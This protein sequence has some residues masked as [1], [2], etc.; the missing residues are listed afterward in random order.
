TKKIYSE[1]GR[2]I[3]PK[4]K[5]VDLIDEL[6]RRRIVPYQVL[7]MM[8]EV[9]KTGNLAV[10]EIHGEKGEA[11]FHLKTVRKIAVWFYKTFCDKHCKVGAFIPPPAPIDASGILKAELE[12]LKA[13]FIA[14]QIRI[15]ELSE[16]AATEA[17]LRALAE[18]QA[19]QAYEE[20]DTAL[21]IGAEDNERLS[22][23]IEKYEALLARQSQENHPTQKELEETVT[24]AV[25]IENE[26]VTEADTREIID[27][28]LRQAGWTVDSKTI[29]HANGARPEKNKCIAISEWPTDSGPADYVLFIG[30]MPVAVVEAKRKNIDVPGKIGQAKRYSKTIRI[31]GDLVAPFDSEPWQNAF[32]IPFMYSANGRPY[33]K[34][35]V[36]KSGIWF[37]DGRRA[38]NISRPLVGWH[39]PEGLKELLKLDVDKTEK[40]L[41][42]SSNDYLPLWP[43][44]REAIESVEKGVIEGRREMLVAMATG[45]GKTR[46]AI[47][48]C[49]R[50]AKAERFRRVLFIVDRTSLGEQAFDSFE[51][52]QLENNQSFT[53]IYDVKEL[54][55]VKP[56]KDTRLQFCTIQGLIHRVLANDVP[57]PVD[58]YDCIIID[59]CHRGYTLDQEMTD[60]EIKFRDEADYISKYMR[61]LEYFDAVKIGL[62]AT[63]A[64]H[65]LALFGGEE[66][67][68]IYQYSYR[69]AVI[70]NYLNDHEPPF[71]ADTEKVE[72]GITFEAGEELPV[73]NSRTD[74]IELTVVP[75]QIKFDVS[76]FNSKVITKGFNKAVCEGLAQQIDPNAPGKTLVFCVNDLHADMVV[77][78]L[79]KAFRKE[80]HKI[81]DD[82]IK[83]IT[84]S[85]DKP[86]EWILKMKN[87]KFPSVVVTVDLLTTGINV[88]EITNLVFLRRVRSRILYEQMIG[89]AT[90]KC[91][92]LYGE[93]KHKGPFRIYDAVKL[94]E[95]L[96][97]YTSM[98]PVVARPSISLR[99]MMTELNTVQ[100]NNFLEE[101]KTQSLG[102]ISRKLSRA[103]TTQ[104]SRIEYLSGL[105]SDKV[106]QH[107]ESLSPKEV[108]EW[109]EKHSPLVEYLH[110]QPFGDGRQ[111]P[112]DESQDTFR[113]WKRGYGDAKRPEDYLESFRQYIEENRDKVVALQ[114]VTQRPR[115]LT[116][117][118][119]KELKLLLD[120][121]GFPQIN[122]FTAYKATTN[123]DIAASIIGFIRHI[124]LN[125]PLENFGERVDRAMADVRSM[126]D[127]NEEQSRWL[128]RIEKQIRLETI[129]D[130]D[131]L[132]EGRFKDKGGFKMIDKA[133]GGRLQE[134]LHRIAASIWKT[135]A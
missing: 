78:A 110:K 119:L 5:H 105:E 84:G 91:E 50:L 68:A 104:L 43:F 8:H 62:T 32:H 25:A 74:E 106:I 97:P 70:E 13:D 22:A 73:L 111:T 10:H 76:E 127:W 12:E 16:S 133:F 23:K 65:T 52:L 113:E 9:R 122:L 56:D 4:A 75:D 116:R 85:I 94:Y 39:S 41:S 82:T 20:L 6:G 96:L 118:Q 117:K 38:D 40:E 90:R 107:L 55:D 49:Y 35:L 79:K 33:I 130:R 34:Q 3:E 93:G 51:D 17:E 31:N 37:Y 102:K 120:A 29:R 14:S 42:E 123:Q 100:D 134:V 89:R 114:M 115:D 66:R 88:P 53:Q 99:Q 81:T 36:E 72:N 109:L 71:Q 129:V 27:R 124:I 131:A 103:N 98:K 128:D 46:T 132:E 57:P 2:E 67:K 21:Q 121:E 83:K 69:K 44:Q 112:I 59:E 92:N 87:E 80:G 101:V 30:L 95:G 7:Q 48:L 11:L 86:R 64:Q 54:G 18:E 28:Q 126:S 47:C 63:P 125:T 135:A 58:E 60:G 45:T 77:S 19:K 15:Q 1:L 61:V 108:G 26:V 24:L